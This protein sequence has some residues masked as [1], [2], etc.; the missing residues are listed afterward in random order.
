MPL[1]QDFGLVVGESDAAI[2]GDLEAD[3]INNAINF[4]LWERWWKKN[5]DERRVTRNVRS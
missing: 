3:V 4:V 1:L 2:V 5:N